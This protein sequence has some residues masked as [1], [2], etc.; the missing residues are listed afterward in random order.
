MMQNCICFCVAA[1]HQKGLEMEYSNGLLFSDEIMKEIQN[2]F[3]YLNED[4]FIGKRLFFDNAGGSFRLK[5]VEKA[6]TEIDSIP[7]CPERSHKMALYLQ[8]IQSKGEAD[9]R[10][11][12]NAPESG[13]I[14]SSLTASQVMFQMVGT[15]AENV[16]GT[17]I[18]TSVL[19]LFPILNNSHL[20]FSSFILLLSKA[21]L[22]KIDSLKE[23]CEPLI[24]FSESDSLIDLLG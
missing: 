14:I 4:K 12:L 11:I 15:I 22:V 24:D 18:V 16:T 21:V 20:K 9:I 5:S 19:D 10:L 3:L 17:N 8:D 6:F 23:S 13:S 1:L 2:E 7:D